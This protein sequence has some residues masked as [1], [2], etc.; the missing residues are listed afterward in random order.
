MQ[1]TNTQ[2]LQFSSAAAYLQD[3]IQEA[4]EDLDDTVVDEPEKKPSSPRHSQ[5]H[6]PKEELDEPPED[7]DTLGQMEAE[8]LVMTALETSEVTPEKSPFHKLLSSGGFFTMGLPTPP[9]YL[10]SKGSTPS[11]TLLAAASDT[12]GVR[13]Y[14]LCFLTFSLSS[15]LSPTG[16]CTPFHCF[17]SLTSPHPPPTPTHRSMKPRRPRVAHPPCSTLRVSCVPFWMPATAPPVP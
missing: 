16:M 15:F 1:T 11:D 10:W 17:Y 5:T 9:P 12:L 2:E 8:A 14:L 13:A 6:S 7:E 3:T 4:L